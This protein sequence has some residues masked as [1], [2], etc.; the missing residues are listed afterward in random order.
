[1]EADAAGQAGPS[2]TLWPRLHALRLA[3]Y[4]LMIVQHCENQSWVPSPNAPS[5][6]GCCALVPG[7]ISG[8]FAVPQPCEVFYF[9][10]VF[11]PQA[12]LHH[13]PIV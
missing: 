9:C 1:M 3:S 2:A 12:N 8:M 6:E 4:C 11:F 7:L 13:L 5:H 10:A